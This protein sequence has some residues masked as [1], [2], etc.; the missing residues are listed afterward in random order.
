MWD[1]SVV[2]PQNITRT[3]LCYFQVATSG[4]ADLF[5]LP[6]KRV[7]SSSFPFLPL[8]ARLWGRVG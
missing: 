1:N 8:Y 3:P 7:C 5:G 4:D 2:I 6:T